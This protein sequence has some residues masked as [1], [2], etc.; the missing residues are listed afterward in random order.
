MNIKIEDKTYEV[1][2]IDG[3]TKDDIV[4]MLPIDI[5]LSRFDNHEYSGTL[6]NKPRNDNNATS[7]IYAGHIYYW[8]GWNSFVINYKDLNIAPYKVVHIGEVTDKSMVEY[9]IKFED[10]ISVR[11]ERK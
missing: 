11:L 4:D 5:K 7:D 8:D 1:N 6:P 2:L 9:L 10:E 3:I